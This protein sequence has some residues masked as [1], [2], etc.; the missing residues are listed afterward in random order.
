MLRMVA[1][2]CRL[3][4]SEFNEDFRCPIALLARYVEVHLSTDGDQIWVEVERHFR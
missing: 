4:L 3:A 2:V 1:S